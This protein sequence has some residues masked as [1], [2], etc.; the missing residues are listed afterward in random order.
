V[1]EAIAWMRRQ[2]RAKAGTARGAG[3]RPDGAGERRQGAAGG[4]WRA[5]RDAA[6]LGLGAARG[7]PARGAGGGHAAGGAGRRR[8]AGDGGAGEPAPR[9]RW[10]PAAVPGAL[11]E[12]RPGGREGP[13]RRD[14]GRAPGRWCCRWARCPCWRTTPAGTGNRSYSGTAGP[15]VA[16]GTPPPASSMP[17]ALARRRGPAAAGVMVHSR[18]GGAHL[19]AAPGHQRPASGGTATPCAPPAGRPAVPVRPCSPLAIAEHLTS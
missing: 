12:G 4:G 17:P 14:P 5:A 2:G 18:G 19:R 7:H 10:G 3:V 11:R 8:S 9:L 1:S 15:G 6:C 13:A 16:G